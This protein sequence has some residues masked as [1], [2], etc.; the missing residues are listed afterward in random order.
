MADFE[1]R[2]LFLRFLSFVSREVKTISHHRRRQTIFPM[3]KTTTMT[4]MNVLNEE[5]DDQNPSVKTLYEPTE[6]FQF[7]HFASCDPPGVKCGFIKGE[8]I[9]LLRTN[10][11]RKKF[12]EGLLKFKQHLKAREYPENIIERSLSGVNFV[13]GQ[14]ALIHTQ[15]PKGHGRLLICHN[16]PLGRLKI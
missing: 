12:E 1:H 11:S 15:K 2:G 13:S 9:R 5:N 16:V 6:T 8:A 10:S 3:T 14:S 4:E 7:T